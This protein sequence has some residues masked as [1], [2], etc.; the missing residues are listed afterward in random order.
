MKKMKI[1]VR[2]LLSLWPLLL[3]LPISVRSCTEDVSCTFGLV[4]QCGWNSLS[5]KQFEMKWKPGNIYM[6][7]DMGGDT[8]AHVTSLYG[9]PLICKTNVTH[10]F[11]FRYSL[12]NGEN[13]HMTSYAIRSD[14][15][16]I[17]LWDTSVFMESE[18]YS[19]LPPALICPQDT[20]FQIIIQVTKIRRGGCGEVRV[21]D[22]EY[23]SSTSNLT[24]CTV[25]PS[26]ST[27]GLQR[28]TTSVVKSADILSSLKSQSLTSNTATVWSL[29]SETPHTG[30][31]PSSNSAT[32]S[33]D[34]RETTKKGK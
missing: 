24:T 20:V 23:Y 31:T 18:P 3:T 27:P 1:F 4:G 5:E 30:T 8:Q 12:E 22:V 34:L 15:I 9:S 32:S 16:N 10:S 21:D 28:K 14:G 11:T 6:S 13:C 33:T 26:T 17:S 19:Q 25:T 2:Q 29:S 7:V